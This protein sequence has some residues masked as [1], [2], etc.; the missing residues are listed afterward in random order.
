MTYVEGIMGASIA[1][2][3]DQ[4]RTAAALT[5]P[6]FG[7]GAQ[8]LDMALMVVDGGPNGRADPAYDAH[9][10]PICQWSMAVWEQWLPLRSLLTL[11]ASA[12]VRLISASRVW[13]KVYGLAAAMVAS[14]TRINWVVVDGLNLVADKGKPMHLTTDPP[15]VIRED[16]LETVRRWRW[17]NI[18]LAM[19]QIKMGAVMQ[20]TRKLLTSRQNG[21]QWNP[22]LRGYLR[23]VISDRQCRQVRL[24]A[25]G[26][27]VHD[28]RVFCLQASI[29]A[30]RKAN[31]EGGPAAR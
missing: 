2:F 29:V 21:D 15:D 20:P 24:Q 3:R 8:N 26:K 7:T 16:C 10:L 22:R 14:C 13:A 12:K 6:A 28:R 1:L 17:K 11:V 27:A 23:S 19:P 25:A 5:C 18:S 30:V 31:R 9:D 4:R